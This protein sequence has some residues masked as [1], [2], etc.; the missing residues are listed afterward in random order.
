MLSALRHDLGLRRVDA[1]QWHVL[2]Q[3]EQGTRPGV[4]HRVPH[5][6]VWIPR[7]CSAHTRTPDAAADAA[8]DAAPDADTTADAAAAAAAATDVR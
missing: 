1:Q 7:H 3:G 4:S 6:H 8:A 2:R 5:V